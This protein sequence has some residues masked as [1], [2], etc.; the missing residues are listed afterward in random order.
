MA[1]SPCTKCQK[2]VT[3]ASKAFQCYWCDH[4]THI[5]CCEIAEDLCRQMMNYHRQNM[6]FCCDNCLPIMERARN[7]RPTPPLGSVDVNP[8]GDSPDATSDEDSLNATCIPIQPP[9]PNNDAAIA[10]L[11]ASTPRK[12]RMKKRKPDAVKPMNE[13]PNL[14]TTKLDTRKPQ[15]AEPK[16]PNPRS[17]SDLDARRPP[18]ERCL[19][20]LNLPESSDEA[21]QARLDHD[22]ESLRTCLASLFQKEEAD[23]ASS[24]NLKM[25]F[26][27][28][29]RQD[30]VVHNARPLKI[31]LGSHIE[32][33]AI[34]R[35]TYRLKG[36]P[37]RILRDLSPEDRVKLKAALTELRDRRA[38]GEMNLIVKDFRVV[39]RKPRIRWLPIAMA[40]GL[41]T[42]CDP[43]L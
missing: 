32:A 39:K 20:V 2:N 27:L 1:P 26:R 37:V 5:R 17:K 34:L 35:R 8:E 29:R 6:N 38:N 4:W 9:T 23:V 36:Q 41:R 12:R 14:D 11:T 31:V 30:P 43:G 24:I 42:P 22:V 40:N 18:R 7:T 16:V 13:C 25:A 10:P 28:G 33:Q 19:I 15:D 21:S 3:A